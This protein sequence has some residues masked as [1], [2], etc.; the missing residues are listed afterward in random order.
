MLSYYMP[1]LLGKFTKDIKLLQV[2]YY[3]MLNAIE[4]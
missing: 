3:L 1:I 2:N 4:I